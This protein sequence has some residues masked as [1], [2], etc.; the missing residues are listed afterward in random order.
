MIAKNK[1]CNFIDVN[2]EEDDSE[3]EKIITKHNKQ[4]Y[5]TKIIAKLRRYF[6]LSNGAK[7]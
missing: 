2:I 3:M 7:L 6:A 1:K 4:F 5:W